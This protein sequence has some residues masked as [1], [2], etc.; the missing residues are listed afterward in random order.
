MTPSQLIATVAAAHGLTPE[1]LRHDRQRPAPAARAE[2]YRALRELGWSYPRIGDFFGRH[3]TTV[4][5]AI[6]EQRPGY[7]ER[8]RRKRERTCADDA[9]PIG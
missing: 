6:Y 7:L 3:H 2:V 4:M 9:P 1:Q 5:V 8:C